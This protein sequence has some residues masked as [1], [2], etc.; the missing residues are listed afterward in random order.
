MIPNRNGYIASLARELSSQAQRVRDLIGDKHWLTDGHHKEYILK[1]LL[2]RHIPAGVALSRGFIVHPKRPD[3]V[4]RE[5]DLLVIDTLAN[6]PVF[7]QGGVCVAFPQQ[8]LGAIAVKT[9]FSTQQFRDACDTLYSVR[10]LCSYTGAAGPWCGVLFFDLDES[11]TP[12]DGLVQSVAKHAASFDASSEALET[13]SSTPDLVAIVGRAGFH[14]DKPQPKDKTISVRG[15]SGDGTVLLL[16]ALMGQIA[17][18]RGANGADF[19]DFA[20]GYELTPLAGSPH[21]ERTDTKR[22]SVTDGA[23]RRSSRR[24]RTPHSK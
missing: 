5:Q 17:R 15:F 18:S 13:T 7:D 10:R 11:A 19:E 16:H 8:V 20:S 4:S 9:R 1:Y 24:K 23:G 6:A 14:L 22:K 3:L 2:S 21:S 12:L